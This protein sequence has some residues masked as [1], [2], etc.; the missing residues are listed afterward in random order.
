VFNLSLK[1]MS[2]TLTVTF[3]GTEVFNSL[4]TNKRQIS[5]SPK[6]VKRKVD[7]TSEKPQ[8]SEPEKKR[9]RRRTKQE[10]VASITV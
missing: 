3:N 10:M 5:E 1:K 8:K 9:R 2:L 4:K 6:P 7:E